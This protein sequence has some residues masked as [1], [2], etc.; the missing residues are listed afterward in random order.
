MGD[1]RP[2]GAYEGLGL[3]GQLSLHPSLSAGFCQILR[4]II[5]FKGHFY[6]VSDGSL[7]AVLCPLKFYF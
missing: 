3:E 1:G 7:G 4:G 5:D 2:Q 6:Q